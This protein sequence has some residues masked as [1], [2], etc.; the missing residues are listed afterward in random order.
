MLFFSVWGLWMV[1]S[2]QRIKSRPSVIKD[3]G[4]RFSSLQIRNLRAD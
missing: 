4:D 1:S 2:H 3:G